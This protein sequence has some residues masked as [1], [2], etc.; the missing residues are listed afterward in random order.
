MACTLCKN[1]KANVNSSDPLNRI[2]QYE[3][4]NCGTYQLSDEVK[5]LFEQNHDNQNV[6]AKVASFVRKKTIYQEGPVLIF[7]KKSDNN[8]YSIPLDEIINSFPENIN[9]RI[10]LLMLNLSKKSSFMGEQLKFNK[11]DFPVFYC[12][13]VNM[14]SY[15]FMINTLN[16]MGY[17]EL[18][19]VTDLEEFANLRDPYII[20]RIT[21][22][23]WNKIYKIKSTKNQNSS[24]AFVAM[25]F[26]SSL[27]NAYTNG[28]EKAIRECGYTPNRV[29]QTEHNEKICDRI[30]LEIKRS[31]F[32]VCDF[33]G[34][35]NG[36]YFEAGYGLGLKLPVIW[37]CR[38][39][40]LEKTHFDTRQYNHIVWNDEND[41]YYKLKNR[42]MATIT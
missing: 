12:D 26:D 2:H 39:D 17:I 37:T 35:R 9:D 1:P 5:K 24:T 33:T 22:E 28:I 11:Y 34:H 42:I 29:D 41:L 38:E 25:S 31:K 6:I 19:T 18:D 23:G 20:L 30:I 40:E 4:P 15:T 10:E 16:K 21:P 32:L 7:H 13:S 36:V 8:P 14:Q 3:C 27:E